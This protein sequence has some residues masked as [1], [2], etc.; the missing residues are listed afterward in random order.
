MTKAQFLSELRQR[1]SDL[2]YADQKRSLDYYSEMIDDRVEDGLSEEDAVKKIGSPAAAATQI[3]QDMPITTLARARMGR[4]HSSFVTVLIILSSPI[5]ISLLA[6]YFSLIV[7]AI[8]V[9]FSL[10]AV[11][12]SLIVTFWAVE[13]SF[14]VCALG[15][16]AAGILSIVMEQNILTGLLLLGAALILFA[17]TVFGYYAAR[18]LTKGLILLCG[19]I[20]KAYKLI[21]RFIKFTL[22]RKE[23][24]R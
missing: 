11:L 14:A 10:L 16:T 3:M 20:L 9:L 24:I 22:I 12:I 2:P 21:F 19:W 1:L 7:T 18:C 5:W 23:A 13:F 8:A 6:V 15:G 4:S 17:L